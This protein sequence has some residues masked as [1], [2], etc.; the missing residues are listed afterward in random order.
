MVF[1]YIYIFCKYIVYKLF[2]YLTYVSNHLNYW[3]KIP[4]L[5]SSLLFFYLQKRYRGCGDSGEAVF[6]LFRSSKTVFEIFSGG[7]MVFVILAVNGIWTF[8]GD[9]SAVKRYLHIFRPKNGIS[10]IFHWERYLGKNRAVLVTHPT[11]VTRGGTVQKC[12]ILKLL[13]ECFFL[14]YQKKNTQLWG[15]VSKHPPDWLYIFNIFSIFKKKHKEWC[16]KNK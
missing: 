1:Y 7:K 3:E 4:L 6:G 9:F 12:W 8:L 13:L 11:P 5:Q 15:E 16:P 2:F 14:K 10:A